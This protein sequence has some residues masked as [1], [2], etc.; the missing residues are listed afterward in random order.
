M[1]L[2]ASSE[3]EIDPSR[4]GKPMHAAALSVWP[5]SLR[6]FFFEVR[7]LKVARRVHATAAHNALQTSANLGW[8][9]RAPALENLPFR[10]ISKADEMR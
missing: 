4:K 7:F 3:T 9:E 8:D 1:T 6:L 10:P 2:K 5:S